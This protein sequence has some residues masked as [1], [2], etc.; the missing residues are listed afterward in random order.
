MA[1]TLALRQH[2]MVYI[3]RT[4]LMMV[5]QGKVGSRLPG[6]VIASLSSCTIG[7]HLYS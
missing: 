6:T 7:W 4:R 5:L 3:Y 1:F 2:V